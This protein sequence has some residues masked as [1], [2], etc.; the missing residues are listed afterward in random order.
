MNCGNG[1]K[2]L[3]IGLDATEPSLVQQLIDRGLMPALATLAR[4]GRWLN[5][6][7]PAHIGSGSVWPTFITG[8]PPTAHG[9]YSEWVWRP[10]EMGLERYHGRDLT[11]FWKAFDQK[12]IAV[13]VLDVPFATPVGLGRGF[14]IAEWWAHDSVLCGMQC[15]PEDLVSLLKEIPPHPLSLKRQGAV[16]PNDPAG[17]RQLTADSIEG[18]RLRGALAQR[19]IDH[20]QPAF[21]LIVF[22]E[23][24]HAGHQMWHT[25]ASDHQ[26]YRGLN[27]FSAEPLLHQVYQEIDRQIADLAA[28]ANNAAIMV[29][30]LHGMKPAIGSPAFLPQLLCARGFS[31][32]VDWSSQSWTERRR[33]ALSAIKKRT[34]LPLRHLYYALTPT[35]TIQRVARP[36]MLPVYD[37]GKTR[38][39]SLPTDQYGWI[40]INLEGR[41]AK[42]IVPLMRYNETLEELESMLALLKDRDGQLLVRDVVRTASNEGE[43]LHHKLPDLVVHWNDVAFVPGL[44]IDDTDFEAQH[45]GIKTGQHALDGF[46]IIRGDSELPSRTSIR[47][48]EMGSLMSE[49]LL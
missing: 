16:K 11:P 42:G 26:L 18:I 3:A 4:Q 48:E 14:E 47:A 36:T 8:T 24:H 9:L 39:F 31:Q 6:K 23:T 44:R 2:V 19:L 46:C 7:A 20:A 15:G 21:A 29:F 34:P 38:A 13:G 33:F 40:R 37:W 25:A 1:P 28:K 35:E 32:T 10:A 17:L 45:A 43:A 30:S 12:G 22:P 41:E 49:M 5:V 27:L